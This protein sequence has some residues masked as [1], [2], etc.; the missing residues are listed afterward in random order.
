[1]PF[2]TSKRY[3]KP[4]GSLLHATSSNWDAVI[5]TGVPVAF[6]PHQ[7]CCV[8]DFGSGGNPL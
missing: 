5:E 2:V 6:I 1:M 8:S 4:V 3:S 7:S